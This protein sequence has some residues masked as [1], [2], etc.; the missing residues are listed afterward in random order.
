[1]SCL[2]GV[3][4]ATAFLKLCRKTEPSTGKTILAWQGK[5]SE[6][7]MHDSVPPTSTREGPAKNCVTRTVLGVAQTHTA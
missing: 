7:A 5:G 6:E 4:K 2:Y 1:M 3:S